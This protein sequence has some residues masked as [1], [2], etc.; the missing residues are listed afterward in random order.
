MRAGLDQDI[1][2]LGTELKVINIMV[3]PVLF[4]LIALIVCRGAQTEAQ[5]R[6]WEPRP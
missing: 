2:S 4:A 5:R 6:R 3:V 1:K